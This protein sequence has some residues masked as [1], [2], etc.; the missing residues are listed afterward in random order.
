MKFFFFCDFI[1]MDSELQLDQKHFVCRRE[2]L[3]RVFPPRMTA[4][5]KTPAHETFPPHRVHPSRELLYWALRPNRM[6]QKA[7]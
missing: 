5:M 4:E 7:G 1:G 3:Y 6:W 2:H